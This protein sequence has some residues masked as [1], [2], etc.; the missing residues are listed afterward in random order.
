MRPC[1]PLRLLLLCL[2][3]VSSMPAQQAPTPTPEWLVATVDSVAEQYQHEGRVAGLS[4][5]VLHDG[6]LLLARGYG[7][8]D[9]ATG[10]PATDTTLFAIGSVTKQF[11]TVA[12]LLLQEEGKLSLDDKVSKWYPALTRASD[13]TLRDLVGHLSGYPDYYPLDFVDRRMA[14]AAPTETIIRRYATGAL[15]FEPRTRW[16]YSNTGY[17]IL[18]RILE[19]VSGVPFGQFLERR[20]FRPLGMRHTRYEPDPMGRGLARG[21]HTWALGPLQ[22]ATPEGAGWTG[23]AGG[24]YSTAGDLARWDLA[25]MTGKM[26]Q[27]AS[28]KF[29]TTSQRL[30]S[31]K[32]TGYSGGLSV[33]QQNGWLLLS[34]GGAVSGFIAGNT[35]VPG[36]RSA[37]IVLASAEDGGASS[38]ITRAAFQLFFERPAPAD[39]AVAPDSGGGDEELTP[40]TING[41]DAVTAA[42][43]LFRALQVGTVDRSTLAEEYSHFL[44]AEKVADA[45]TRLGPLGEPAAVELRGQSERGGMEVSLV[46]FRFEGLAVRALMYRTPDGKIEE[47]LLG[48]M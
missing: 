14:A 42:K 8:A 37:V 10:L 16:S 36:S 38:G 5:A 26:V 47:F 9:L 20:I 3:P 18:G 29:L 4:V 7:V 27:P 30:A 40:P 31:G 46:L 21:Y 28:W 11:A 17:L 25:L 34:H 12:A 48:A 1:P 44:S 22:P 35:M 23:A 32:G 2:L 19:R 15:D 41:P 33:G 24:I 43:T 13:I 45:A 39:L 6:R